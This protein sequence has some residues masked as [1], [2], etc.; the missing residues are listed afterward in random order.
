[1]RACLFWNGMRYLAPFAIPDEPSGMLT[2]NFQGLSLRGVVAGADG[3]PASHVTVS[4]AYRGLGT[5][6]AQSV[7]S[8]SD[9]TFCFKGLGAGTVV[10]SARDDEGHTATREV[11]IGSGG[12]PAAV[13][14]DL[15]GKAGPAVA[16][17]P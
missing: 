6:P 11:T 8:G 10:L 3:A 12:P 1:M 17:G 15:G 2:C 14:L 13:R 5:S 16:G 9:G 7:P 4:L